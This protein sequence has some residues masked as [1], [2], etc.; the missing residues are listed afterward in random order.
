M[1]IKYFLV[2]TILALCG[3]CG[4]GNTDQETNSETDNANQTP[5]ETI[6]DNDTEVETP[7]QESLTTDISPVRQIKRKRDRRDDMSPDDTIFRSFDGSD[8]NRR[9]RSMNEAH[10]QLRRISPAAYTDGIASLAGQERPNPRTISS[11]VNAQA[12][13]LPNSARASDYLW[14][15]GQFLDHD[16]DLTDGADPAEPANIE[17]PRGDP[18][19]DPQGTGA[20][21]FSF[22]RSIYDT[23]S[24]SSRRNPREQINEIS[25][26]IDA[27]NVYGSDEE[28]AEALRTNDSTGMLLTSSGNLLPFNEAGLANAGGESA[29]LF[30]AGDVRANEQAG[31][32]AMHTLF[33]REHNRLA[34]IIAEQNPSYDG[35]QIY[36]S[37]RKVVGAQMQVIT[38]N[39]FLPLLL[40]SNAI[41]AYD[42]YDDE[43][44]AS[45]TNEF[46]SAAYRLGHSM[47][48]TT[49][50]RLDAQNNEISEGNLGLRDAFF[51]PQILVNEG[52]I[53]PIL[54]GLA[55]QVCQT[56]DVFVVDDVRNFLFG[57]PG[58]G[59]FDLVSLNIQRGRDH[60]LASYN[61]MR[62][63]FGLER[64]TSFAEITSSV[65]LQNRLAS[66]YDSVDELDAWVA[67][68]AED[69]VNGS[70]LGELF[71]EIIT[72]QFEALR[73]GD[74]F[75]YERSLTESE[76]ALLGDVSL[77]DIIRRNTSI[78]NEI[79]DNVFVV[80]N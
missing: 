60:G 50:L 3:A 24:G 80:D 32:A 45:I 64:K 25:G 66:V 59:G 14:Q 15:W 27:S 4:G 44:D 62:E 31:L 18:E 56:I 1:K 75:W 13:S 33:V 68:L 70:M 28:R 41:S 17:I 43:V 30:V 38:Y 65:D 34:A 39:E 58:Q 47:L 46:S 49:I 6:D 12:V 61:D 74:Q 48:S 72:S 51:S 35:D 22:N 16:I 23:D 52:G 26:W 78:G 5:A 11:A 57:A 55:A 10:T 9:T 2:T 63:A 20:M 21:E 71:H 40:G 19:F 8:N 53:E 73:D 77:A 42:G 67:G 76:Q 69:P 7:V 37:A 79:S 29:E 54:R 36:Q